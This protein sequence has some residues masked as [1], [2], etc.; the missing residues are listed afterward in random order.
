MVPRIFMVF[1]Q[2]SNR[3]VYSDG[4]F[5]RTVASIRIIAWIMEAF[6]GCVY[7]K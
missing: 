4:R 5:Y 7:N 1:R 2:I 6:I 3:D